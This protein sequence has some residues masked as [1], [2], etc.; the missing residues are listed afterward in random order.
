MNT[1]GTKPTKA[2]PPGPPGPAGAAGAAGATGATGPAGP[3]GSGGGTFTPGS[4]PFADGAGALA[5]DNAGFFWDAAN[6]RL[7]IGNNTPVS[8]LNVRNADPTGT[9]L[10]V[11]NT[12]GG[13]AGVQFTDGSTVYGQLDFNGATND[14][15]IRAYDK[16][17]F[18]PAMVA[19]P[20]VTFTANGRVRIGGPGFAPYPTQGGVLLTS[21]AA[22]PVGLTAAEAYLSIGGEEYGANSYRTLAF[23]WFNGGSAYQPAYLT[24]KETDSSAYTRGDLIFGTRRSTAA[25]TVPDE[26]LRVTASGDVAIGAV[27][28]TARL[29]LPAG[30]AGAGLAPLKLEPGVLLA[31]PEV[32]AVEFTDDGT[33]GH[34]YVTV[35]V[36]GVPTRIQIV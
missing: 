4:I 11:G 19:A 24:Y 13:P 22:A 5:E 20:A 35:N 9:R 6:Q 7:G 8:A 16:I 36:A 30:A 34:L 18:C 1:K 29:H 10:R 33:T 14:L 21:K 26:T 23:G 3:P 28:P 32:G 17:L 15:W 2:G 25:D 12:G 27:V 31:T